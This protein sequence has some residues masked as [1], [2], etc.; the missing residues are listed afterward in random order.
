MLKVECPDC[1]MRYALKGRGDQT[2]IKCRKCGA[3]IA[4]PEA[5]TVTPGMAR[6]ALR[7]ELSRLAATEL[8]ADS[9]TTASRVHIEEEEDHPLLSA[10]SQKA[11]IVGAIILFLLVFGGGG[12]WLHWHITHDDLTG[13][14]IPT[15]DNTPVEDP[16]EVLPEPPKLS[17]AAQVAWDKAEA[18][19]AGPKRAALALWDAAARLLE[20]ETSVRGVPEM[21]Q[22][23]RRRI[24]EIE[25]AFVEARSSKLAQIGRMVTD[26]EA[27]ANAG[28]RAAAKALLEQ[29]RTELGAIEV[30]G[31]DVVR[32]GERIRLALGSLGEV[33]IDDASAPP[34]ATPGWSVLDHPI[35]EQ[36]WICER[37]GDA[38][39]AVF[40]LKGDA[41]AKAQYVSMQ[42]KKGTGGKWVASLRRPVNLSKYDLLRIHMRVKGSTSVALGIWVGSELYESRPQTVQE[43]DGGDG[44]RE[45]TF[46]LR[47]TTFKSKESEW[48]DKTKISDLGRVNKMSLMF[49][50]HSRTPIEFCNLSVHRAE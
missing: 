26:A 32:M 34:P 46:N 16:P 8:A 33:A 50:R 31:D 30:D 28:Q 42:M 22:R 40:T 47:A 11:V 38:S 35:N 24:G 43:K 36:R 13:G 49:Y 1:K 10:S 17:D 12:F 15:E 9:A 14:V 41:K 37:W 6:T 7:E 2:A 5:P 44:W 27:Q 39:L 20:G 3:T 45:V 21:L 48:Q 29:A 18:G 23:A 19:D 25:L 4:L